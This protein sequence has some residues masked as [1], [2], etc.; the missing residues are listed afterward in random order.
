MLHKEAQAAYQYAA[1]MEAGIDQWTCYIVL[2]NIPILAAVQA[3]AAAIELSHEATLCAQKAS[4]ALVSRGMFIYVT[5]YL[6][7]F[8]WFGIIGGRGHGRGRG[9]GRGKFQCFI[10]VRLHSLFIFEGQARRRS[11]RSG[12]FTSQ[13][14]HEGE[15]HEYHEDEG[16]HYEDY[17]HYDEGGQESHEQGRK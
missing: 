7:F 9:R 14:E 12:S 10:F 8:C 4:R 17:E 5:V 13:G 11:S 2:Y 15:E 6:I 3:Q 16:N 1:E